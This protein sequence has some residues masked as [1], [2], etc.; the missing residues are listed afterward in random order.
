MILKN[1]ALATFK[2]QPCSVVLRTEDHMNYRRSVVPFFPG[3]RCAAGYC[4][5]SDTRV[6]CPGLT[7]VDFPEER[8]E[9]VPTEAVCP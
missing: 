8:A 6:K 1:D 4:P 2:G 7:L 9:R 5:K 3:L